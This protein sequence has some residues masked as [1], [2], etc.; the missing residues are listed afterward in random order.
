MNPSFPSCRCLARGH[1]C[2][3]P[4]CLQTC[5]LLLHTHFKLSNSDQSSA[6]FSFSHLF[7]ASENTWACSQVSY[8]PPPSLFGAFFSPLSFS[9][10]YF[11]FKYVLG[12]KGSLFFFFLWLDLPPLNFLCLYYFFIL[13][14][15]FFNCNECNDATEDSTHNP[16]SNYSSP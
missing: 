6:Q 9:S 3:L 16:I 5:T 1:F 10:F 4:H 14:L 15:L 12:L 7:T 2:F 11:S 8:L 13:F